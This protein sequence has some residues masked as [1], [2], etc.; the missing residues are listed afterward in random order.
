MSQKAMKLL[1]EYIDYRNDNCNYVFVTTRSPVRKMSNR[2]IQR[3]IGLIA[4]RANIKK[5]VSPKTFRHTFAKALLSKDCPMYIVQ[6]LLGYK[7]YTT[8][9]VT[10]VRVTKENINTIFEKYVDIK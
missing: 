9:S 10:N 1:R 3:E 6:T 2:A 7:D 8:T 5:D 4:E